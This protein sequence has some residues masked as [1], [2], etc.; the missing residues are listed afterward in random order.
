[1]ESMPPGRTPSA[2]VNRR[3]SSITRSHFCSEVRPQILERSGFHTFR[4]RSLCGWRSHFPIF[5]CST[6]RLIFLILHVWRQTKKAIFNWTS[7]GFNLEGFINQKSVNSNGKRM[8][9][10]EQKTHNIKIHKAFSSF[11]V[12]SPLFFV[13]IW[14]NKGTA[15]TCFGMTLVGAFAL[16]SSQIWN[17]CYLIAD[18]NG[19]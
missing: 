1:M 9:K 18:I 3:K 8:S 11:H 15:V 16:H 10:E 2:E 7:S 12:L 4:N 17:F 5:G 6:K 19:Q 13:C 14:T